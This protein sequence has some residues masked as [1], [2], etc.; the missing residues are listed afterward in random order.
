MRYG[1]FVAPFG[2]LADPAAVAE[3]AVKAEARGFDG[4][5]LWDHIARPH[6]TSL[7]VADPWVTMAA[8]ASRTERL[9]LGPMV[10]PLARRRPQVV[11]RQM[12]TLDQLSGGRLVF[13]AGLGVNTGGELSRFGEVDDDRERAGMLDEGLDL[14][15]RL[16][17]G[18]V[19][20]HEGEHYRAE[21]VQFLPRPLQRPR[22]PVWVAARSP[23]Q[24]PLRRAA[25]FDGFFVTRTTPETVAE[26][27]D[28][29]QSHRDSMAGFDVVACGDL[30]VDPDPYR[31]VGATWW[32]T[33]LPEISTYDEAAAVIEAGPP[34]AS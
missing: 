23:R 25:R 8:V 13:G 6:H 28:I 26:M 34:T 9:L 2:E 16:W 33:Y 24:R 22:I 20:D 31:A 32:L 19:V 30:D 11:A 27:V 4:L 15:C 21:G 12:A 29:V 5:F 10:T 17:S 1:M 3:L 18:E 14:L 7:P